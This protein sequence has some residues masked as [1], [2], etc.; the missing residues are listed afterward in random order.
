MAP[1][2]LHGH[3]LLLS[4]SLALVS[5][6]LGK[7]ESE[8]SLFKQEKRFVLHG[9]GEQGHG[10]AGDSFTMKGASGKE[11]EQWVR[12]AGSPLHM[13]HHIVTLGASG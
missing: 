3:P 11:N 8:I 9:G 6:G 7:S 2:G 13:Q 12:N 4:V 5:T 1:P 10:P